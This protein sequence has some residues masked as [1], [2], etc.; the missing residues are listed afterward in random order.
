MG[1]IITWKMIVFK[2][3]QASKKFSETKYF[4]EKLFLCMFNCR[5][6]FQ[7]F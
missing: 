2:H 7:N 4:L 1:K 5:I 6:M 3:L